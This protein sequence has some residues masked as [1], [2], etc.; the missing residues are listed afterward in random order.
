M[1][2]LVAT[3]DYMLLAEELFAAGAAISQDPDMLGSIRGEDMMKWLLMAIM[4]VGF[5]LGAAG[6]TAVAD[7][8]GV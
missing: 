5:L 3:C 1:P 7:L 2:F 4:V 8:L 6:I